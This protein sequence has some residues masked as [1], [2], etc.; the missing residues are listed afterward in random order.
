M[1]RFALEDLARAKATNRAE[2]I[3]AAQKTVD[4]AF[5]VAEAA[6]P[7]GLQTAIA[8][9]QRAIVAAGGK[10]FLFGTPVISDGETMGM[11]GM[12]YSLVSREVIADSIE[13]ACN[14]QSMDGLLAIGGCDKNMPGAMLAMA[15]MN[16]PAI[17]V[18]GGTIK[19]GRLGPCDLTVVSAFE[20]VG[21]YSGGRIDV[22]ELT[23]GQTESAAAASVASGQNAT[24]VI[25]VSAGLQFQLEAAAIQRQ[26]GLEHQ[27]PRENFGR[28]LP[29]ELGELIAHLLVEVPD[30]GNADADE[31]TDREEQQAPYA[32]FEHG[33][34]GCRIV[35]GYVHG[36]LMGRFGSFYQVADACVRLRNGG[37]P[38]RRAQHPVYPEAR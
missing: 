35:I 32:A 3:E 4:E 16:I 15:R 1:A 2:R 8:R 28:H 13:T 12:K 29:V 38:V 19:P 21:Q 5:A 33:V 25:L 27:R 36:N 7:N 14:A 10:P 20:A 31:K 26:T 24:A 9:L 6:S 11:E 37:L 34:V 23:G 22:E 18:Y 30:V 17:F